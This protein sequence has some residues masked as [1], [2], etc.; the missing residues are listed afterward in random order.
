MG[1]YCG[2]CRNNLNFWLFPIKNMHFFP[3]P[4][5]WA[6]LD[7]RCPLCWNEWKIKFPIFIFWV[8][9]DCVYNF[10]WRNLISKCVADQITFFP[11]KVV[12]FAWKMRNEL[13][14]MKKIN[15]AIF[16]FQDIYSRFCTEIQKFYYVKGVL[17][18]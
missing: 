16:N 10:R 3:H 4:R 14:R 8:M 18:P 6:D 7:E 13:K 17:H 1:K 15:F 11:S 9:V 5:K 12:K 2:K